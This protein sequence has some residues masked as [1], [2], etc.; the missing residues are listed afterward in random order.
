MD[1]SR[2][3]ARKVQVQG[4]PGT[5]CARKQQSAQRLMGPCQKDPGAS[6]KCHPLTKFVTISS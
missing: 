4:E 2:C 5:S 3:E 6:K 1:D